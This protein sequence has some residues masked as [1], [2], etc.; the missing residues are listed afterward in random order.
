LRLEASNHGWKVLFYRPSIAGLVTGVEGVLE[1]PVPLRG[2]ACGLP[3][4]LSA[5]F[6]LAVS[7]PK[8]DGVNVTVIVQ[9]LPAP[10][11]DPHVLV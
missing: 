11:L 4:A 5:T 3:V 1:I 2:I 8:M 9:L 6:T 7:D 10:T